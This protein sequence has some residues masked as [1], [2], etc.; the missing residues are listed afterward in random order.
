MERRKRPAPA[1]QFRVADLVA[2]HHLAADLAGGPPLQRVVRSTLVAVRLARHLQLRDEDVATTYWVTLLAGLGHPAGTTLAA[3]L[4]L[5]TEIEVALAVR[6]EL[7]RPGP[8]TRRDVA[9]GAR[10]AVELACL[11]SAIVDHLG[12]LAGAAVVMQRWPDPDLHP[13]LAHT[14]TTSARPLLHDLADVDLIELTAAEPDPPLVRTGR[15]V[16]RTL[17]ALGDRDDAA[18]H[19]TTGHARAVASLAASTASAAGLPDATQ[20]TL[21]Q[22]GWVHDLGRGAAPAHTWHVHDP[23]TS[24]EIERM[25]MTG[26]LTQVMLRR[27]PEL[28][29]VA[30]VVSLART[31][32]AADPTDELV[33]A[34]AILAAAHRYVSLGEAR[35]HRRGLSRKEAARSLWRAGRASQLSRPAVNAV[36]RTAD[37]PAREHP[38]EDSSLRLLTPRELEVLQLIARGASARRVGAELS[39]T[40]K[41]ASNHITRI[42]TKLGISSRAEAALF[43]VRH[44]LLQNLQPLTVDVD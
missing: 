14:S 32:G 37:H 1:D 3:A 39:I 41:T 29:D 28:G 9:P 22:A 23:P 11:A 6:A 27:V 38:D 2:A 21:R 25:R 20:R 15:A 17:A 13:G 26:H 18:G 12:D 36:L 40:A 24:A 34:G 5:G 35:S 30:T 42:Y 43:A 10:R 44:Q 19:G 31:N 7:R 4:G 16:D 33:A 8:V